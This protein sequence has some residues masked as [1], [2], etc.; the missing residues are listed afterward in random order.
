MNNAHFGMLRKLRNDEAFYFFTALGNYTGQSARSLEEF[1]RGITEI[2]AKSLEFHLFR[3]DF[4]K[5]V[6]LTIGDVQLA[7]DLA[8]L[9]RQKIARA[10]LRD[11]LSF[12]VS[13]RLKELVNASL[14]PT[15]KN[16]VKKKGS[17]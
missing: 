17:L 7:E 16:Q 13:K 2:D 14:E 15:A 12:V 5:W 11:R 4:E 3:E 10:D 6:S 9:R 8:M 1:L